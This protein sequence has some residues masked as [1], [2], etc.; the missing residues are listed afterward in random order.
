M[1][2]RKFLQGFELSHSLDRD[3]Y[4]VL[5]FPTLSLKI[6]VVLMVEVKMVMNEN[7]CKRY[8]MFFLIC[9]DSIQVYLHVI[10]LG[11]VHKKRTS[12]VFFVGVIYTQA[13]GNDQNQSS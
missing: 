3:I 7:V 5:L 4:M 10:F 12:P 2:V 8:G 1:F 9:L 11:S 6:S 13:G